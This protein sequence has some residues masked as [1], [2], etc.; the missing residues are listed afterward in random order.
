MSED[1]PYAPFTREQAEYIRRSMRSWL[2][3]AE[4]GKRAGKNVINLIAWAICLET[5]P[6][7]LH[8]CAGVSSDRK[9]VV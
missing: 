5:H 1:H 2:N 7:R 8:L 3:V 4:G 6:D 9:S